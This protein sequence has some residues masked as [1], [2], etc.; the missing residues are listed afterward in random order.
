MDK[1]IKI[2]YTGGLNLG[3]DTA[4]R[5]EMKKQG[6]KWYAQGYNFGSKI[7]EIVFDKQKRIK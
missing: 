7:R 6:H 3:L 4:I 5:N 2:T 1:T